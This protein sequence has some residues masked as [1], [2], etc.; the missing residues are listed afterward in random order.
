MTF[1][2]P[3]LVTQLYR[4]YKPGVDSL[5]AAY[6]INATTQFNLVSVIGY[7]YD[8]EGDTNAAY[9]DKTEFSRKF[10]L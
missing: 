10:V 8:V 7:E 6:D 2:I 9:L 5:V 1:F 4:I 3:F